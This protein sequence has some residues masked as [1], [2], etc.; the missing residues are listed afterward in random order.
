MPRD[1]QAR[2]RLARALARKRPTR[3]P[4]DRVL[5]V[6]EGTKSEPNYFEAICKQLRVASARVIPSASRTAPEQVIEFARREFKR[7][8]RGFE[9]IF[10]VF[11]RDNHPTYANA[12][13]L[14]RRLDNTLKSDQGRA[15]RF[16]AVPSV[17]CFELWLL[18]H[19]EDVWAF[20]H[21]DDVLTKLKRWLP[22]Y[23]KG[24]VDVYDQTKFRLDDAIGRAK[25][26]KQRYQPDT[27]AD[28]YTNVDEV[29]ERLQSINQ[30]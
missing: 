28:P 30:L 18:I 21:R 22:A 13:S 29:V 1:N 5:I 15:V 6:T 2:E 16:V 25:E 19:F 11:D 20:G 9:W 7:R 10:A 4:F 12:L 8:A 3:R 14:A 23:E 24:S 17:P 26:L 27:G